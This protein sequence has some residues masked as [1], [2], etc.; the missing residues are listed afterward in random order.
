[1]CKFFYNFSE[2]FGRGLKPQKGTTF[3][4]S[5]SFLKHPM[6]YSTF[7]LTPTYIYI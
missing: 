3:S 4:M 2:L 1:M 5:E 7:K 6:A